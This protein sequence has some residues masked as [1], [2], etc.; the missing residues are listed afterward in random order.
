MTWE[1]FCKSSPS[2]IL[3]WADDQP[4]SRAMAECAQDVAWH[5]EG[6]VWTHTKMVCA[7]L[8]LLEEWAMLTHPERTALLFTAL[9]HDCGKPLTSHVDP[10]SG[11][12]TSPKH[13][14]K[15]AHLARSILRTLGCNVTTR[16]EIVRL[17]RFHGRP[18]F[19]LEKPQPSHEVVSLSWLVSNKLLYLFALAD[20]R[21]RSTVEMTRP[22]ENLHLWRLVAEENGCFNRP[23]PFAN[24]HARFLFYRQ[25]QPNLHYVPYEGHRCTV[26]LMSGLPGSGK[27]AWLAVNRAEL[28]VVS[29][30]DI[31][32][33]LDVEATDDQGEV[34]QLARERCRE[35]LR[36][37]RSF[38]FNATN[39]LRQTRRRWIDLFADYDARIE[40]VYVEP[41]LPVILSRNGRRDR[42]VPD[43]VI[44]ELCD[45]CEPPTF[46]EAHG[47]VFVC[48]CAVDSERRTPGESGARP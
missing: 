43:G 4:W 12:I 20:T 9:F 28:P 47:L 30:D 1:Q 45:K 19:L 31:R 27:D 3:A 41:P 36:S 48:E 2:D 42:S 29:L 8:T 18:A 13:A 7:Q 21:G 39:I 15:G 17:V 23:F 11:R 25:E 26:T 33:E 6:N 10:G 44:R 22:E 46:T 34:I 14:V 38:A 37:G 16:E 35:L 32:G 40:I 5:S 24:D